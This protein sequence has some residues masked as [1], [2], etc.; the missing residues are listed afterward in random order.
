MP[1]AHQP[2]PHHDEAAE[3]VGG[4]PYWHFIDISTDTAK[5]FMKP[6][7]RALGEAAKAGAPAARAALPAVKLGLR[8]LPV[9]GMAGE[10]VHVYT[11]H[12]QATAD[13][14]AGKLTAR[15]YGELRLL[16]AA[17]VVSGLGGIFTAAAKEGITDAAQYYEWM[18]E[19]YIPHSLLLELHHTGWLKGEFPRHDDHAGKHHHHADATTCAVCASAL[20]TLTPGATPHTGT[21]PHKKR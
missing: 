7:A 12:Q 19:R 13:Y 18:D 3:H 11:P 8:A 6:A 1:H 14:K 16:Y 17:Y 5:A 20:S 10:A 9:V 4:W 2:D 21:T 15:Q